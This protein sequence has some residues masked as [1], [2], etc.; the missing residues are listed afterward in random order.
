MVV[1]ERA[2]RY[3]AVAPVA[4]IQNPAGC[5]PSRPVPVVAFHGTAD[6]FVSYT[7]A[8]GPAA[9]KLQAPDGSHRTLGQYLGKKAAKVRSVAA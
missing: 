7:G 1:L 3:A 2:G 6:P 5:H 8:I 4:G 9:L